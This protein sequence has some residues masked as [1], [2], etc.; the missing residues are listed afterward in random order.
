MYV[1]LICVVLAAM[2]AVRLQDKANRFE[3]AEKALY[4]AV[5]LFFLVR[6]FE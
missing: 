4:V 5:A 3:T 2:A 1:I 6:Y